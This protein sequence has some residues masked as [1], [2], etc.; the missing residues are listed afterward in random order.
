MLM[1]MLTLTWAGADVI[2]PQARI[3]ARMARRMVSLL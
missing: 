1:P 3:S 2:A